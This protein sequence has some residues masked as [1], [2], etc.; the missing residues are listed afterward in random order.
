MKNISSLSQT[1]NGEAL[2]TKA[3]TTL[4]VQFDMQLSGA[5]IPR[6]RRMVND[7]IGAENDL[8]HNHDE[9]GKHKYRYPL[10]QYKTANGNALLLGIADAGVLAVQAFLEHSKFRE[11]RDKVASENFLL[12]SHEHDE[13]LL[14]RKPVNSYRLH[15][16]LALNDANARRWREDKNMVARLHLLE[17][18]LAGHILKFCSAI[19]WRLPPHSLLVQLTDC[20][21]RRVR[22][23]GNPFTAFDIRFRTNI[24]L[25]NYVGLGKAVAH[26]FGVLSSA[27]EPPPSGG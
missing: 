23:R 7:I 8:F 1:A 25:P 19:Q 12:T 5:E 4:A 26:G 14:H 10:V 21:E 2:A 22:F 3:L 11:V 16:W 27:S 9:R 6:F 20:R 17:G 13:L 24:T 18:A 15:H